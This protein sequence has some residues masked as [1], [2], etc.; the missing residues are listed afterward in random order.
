[1]KGSLVHLF[2]LMMLIFLKQQYCRVAATDSKGSNSNLSI[3]NATTDGCV[4]GIH[5][6]SNAISDDL[7]LFMD[8]PLRRMLA[9]KVPPVTRDTVNPGQSASAKIPETCNAYKKGCHNNF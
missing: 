6:C 8:E 3:N 5:D 4:G 2:L 7:S 9:I 1:M